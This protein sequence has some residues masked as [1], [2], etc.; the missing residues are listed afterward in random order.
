LSWRGEPAA[1]PVIAD[2]VVTFDPVPMITRSGNVTIKATKRSALARD[3]RRT[4][5]TKP[6]PL[7]QTDEDSGGRYIQSITLENQDA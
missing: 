7:L 4:S 1:R 2:V 3:G 5:A 6:K